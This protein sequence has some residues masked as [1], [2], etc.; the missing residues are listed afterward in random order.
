MSNNKSNLHVRGC[1]LN[2]KTGKHV[3]ISGTY[4]RASR[5]E[6]IFRYPRY[7]RVPKGSSDAKKKIA[8]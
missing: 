7:V 5:I 8:V 6:L 2:I 3:S 1:Q 4:C